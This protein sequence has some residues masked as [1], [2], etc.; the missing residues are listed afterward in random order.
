[1][2][3]EAEMFRVFRRRREEAL[4][5]QE[6]EAR[7]ERAERA[8]G[9]LQQRAYHAERTLEERANRNHWREALIEMVQG[10]WQ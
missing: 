2:R 8:L 1:V 10:A 3:I 7:L 4:K 5:E 9:A 6:Q